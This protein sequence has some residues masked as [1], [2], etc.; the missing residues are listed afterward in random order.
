M[1]NANITRSNKMLTR[2]N[3]RVTG[4]VPNCNACTSGGSAVTSVQVII[5][6]LTLCTGCILVAGFTD[7]KIV[8]GSFGDGTY[9]LPYDASHSTPPSD[10]CAYFY[11]LPSPIVINIYPSDTGLCTGTPTTATIDTLFI[12]FSRSRPGALYTLRIQA[13]GVFILLGTP[14]AFTGFTLFNF[15][16][17]VTPNC[18]GGTY[19]NL[20]TDCATPQTDAV[21]S[22]TYVPLASGG[23]ATL[24]INGC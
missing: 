7:Y 23:T 24:V 12:T 9:C 13:A 8:S 22:V 1:A 18:V 15:T 3:K 4:C 21:P 16:G 19:S 6:G 10:L 20:M 17:T 2:N 14:T 5:S 11:T